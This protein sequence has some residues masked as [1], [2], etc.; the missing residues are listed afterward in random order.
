VTYFKQRMAYRKLRLLCEVKTYNIEHIKN[1]MKMPDTFPTLVYATTTQQDILN[2]FKCYEETIT[3]REYKEKYTIVAFNSHR[4]AYQEY[5][6]PIFD[7]MLQT[8][9]K[10][11]QYS[12]KTYFVSR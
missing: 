4:N 11:H 5:I 9:C 8:G 2:T 7:M 6:L 12:H 10:F 1:V 3:I